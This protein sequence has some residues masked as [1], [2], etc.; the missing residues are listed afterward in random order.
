MAGAV[1][2]NQDPVSNVRELYLSADYEGA[3]AIL[4]HL[5]RPTRDSHAELADY[6][7][8]CLLALDRRDEARQAIRAIVERDPAHRLSDVQASP[9]MQT[10]FQDLRKALL[11]DIVQQLYAEAKAKFDKHDPSAADTFDRLMTLLDDP[12]LKDAQLSDLRAVASG[13]R[14][15]S[16]SANAVPAQKATSEEVVLTPSRPESASDTTPVRLKADTAYSSEPAATVVP[17]PSG[18]MTGPPDKIRVTPAGA[19]LVFSPKPPPPP[20]VE[21]ALAVSQP[22][23]QWSRRWIKTQQNFDSTLELTIDEQ[24]NVTT[25]ALHQ[26]LHPMFDKALLKLA[27]TWKYTPARLNGT[28][29][30][31]LKLVDIHIQPDR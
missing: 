23:P 5:D 14:D 17:K 21:M 3:L 29:V 16:K 10:A 13:F 2:A 18:P 19:S 27:H 31:F 4:D 15:L 8:L 20:G 26:P 30:P 6:R 12:D 9:R 7:V 1:D 25:V 28:P 11:P 22:I 24:G